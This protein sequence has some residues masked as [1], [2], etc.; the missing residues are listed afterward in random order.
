[1]QY[2]YVHICRAV[3]GVNVPAVVVGY[4]IVRGPLKCSSIFI[5]ETFIKI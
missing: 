5:V 3:N 1:M 2:M 4:R